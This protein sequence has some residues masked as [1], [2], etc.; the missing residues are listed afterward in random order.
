MKNQKGFTL[1]EVIIAATLFAVIISSAYGI[2]SMG[3]QIWRRTQG[4]SLEDRRII[5]AFERMGR[6]IR[7]CLRLPEQSEG[8]GKRVL[9]FQGDATSFEIPGF[10]QF[11]NKRK[12]EMIQPGTIRYEWDR[13]KNSLCRQALSTTDHYL[14]RS[15]DCAV[16]AGAI[17]KA[18]FEYLMYNTFTK[19]YSW[20]DDW[21]SDDGLPQA[22]KV[23][24][25][26][27]P[28][29]QL[30]AFIKPTI[31]ERSFYVPVG[32]FVDLSSEDESVKVL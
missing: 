13:S 28:N 21:K 18:R 8:L 16:I 14:R 19:G 10:V 12:Q 3:I 11:V 22:I 1:M 24:I 7:Q 25:E 20:Y 6:D 15:P 31:Y 29:K 23:T 27:M 2:F 9:T 5:L 30:R 32:G 26:M 4:R 17:K